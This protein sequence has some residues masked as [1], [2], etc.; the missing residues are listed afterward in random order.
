MRNLRSYEI[1]DFLKKRRRCS[2]EELQEKFGVSSATIHRDVAALVARGAVHRVR[3]GVTARETPVASDATR[4]GASSWR[5]RMEV[6]QAAKERIAGQAIRFVSEGD[7]VFLDSSTTVACFADELAKAPIRA[8]TIVTNSV[9]VIEKFA[10]CPP[11]WVLIGLGGSYDAQLHSFLGAETLR[12]LERLALT[13]AFVS[14][15]GVDDRNATTNHE[16]QAG[17]LARVFEM[18]PQKYLLCDKTKLGRI[19]LHRLLPVAGFD[20]T[21]SG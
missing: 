18:A 2:I 3:G 21:I 5:D 1:L 11:Y 13:K 15:F 7:I 20:E 8:L 9:A 4:T 16:Q 14:A 12:Q 6:N 10:V 19:G 17:L